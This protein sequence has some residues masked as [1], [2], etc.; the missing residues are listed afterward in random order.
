MLR[1]WSKRLSRTVFLDG[2]Q[3]GLLREDLGVLKVPVC[4]YI[5]LMYMVWKA[6]RDFLQ[7]VGFF[8]DICFNFLHMGKV[9]QNSV[10][11]EDEQDSQSSY[12]DFVA[13][14]ASNIKAKQA[15]VD[16]KMKESA[17]AKNDKAEAE[18]KRESTLQELDQ[19]YDA[20]VALHKEQCE[21]D[22][23]DSPPTQDFSHP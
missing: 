20:K 13:Q 1:S 23:V 19:L 7:L 14:T 22:D 18:S 6:A 21:V 3:R 11:P 4:F 10:C 17:D 15:E 2:G 9:I 5:H 12:E 16:D 8:A